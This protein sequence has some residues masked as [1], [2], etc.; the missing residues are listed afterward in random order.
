MRGTPELK[1]TGGGT[2][3]D[4]VIE[5]QAAGR[6]YKVERE[7]VRQYL[8][9]YLS[10]TYD[11]PDEQRKFRIDFSYDEADFAAARELVE[12]DN[13]DY[14]TVY[15]VLDVPEDTEEIAA[16]CMIE[17]FIGPRFSVT[18]KAL[19]EFDLERPDDY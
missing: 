10:S 12:S 11:A 6:S 7:D 13:S 4:E 15:D 16:V 14:E 9:S 19:R 3:G 8:E 1:A 2:I 5:S 18:P 17:W